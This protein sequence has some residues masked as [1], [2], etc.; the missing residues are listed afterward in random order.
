MSTFKEWFGRLE[1]FLE[2]R[3][4]TQSEI[5]TLK[6]LDRE[7]R[8]NWSP[9]SRREATEAIETFVEEPKVVTFESREIARDFYE[10]LRS[11]IVETLAQRSGEEF[12]LHYAKWVDRLRTTEDEEARYIGCGIKE[13][14]FDKGEFYFDS[15]DDLESDDYSFSGSKSERPG[16]LI[17]V[18]EGELNFTWAQEDYPGWVRDEELYDDNGVSYG[19]FIDYKKIDRINKAAKESGMN[20][21]T[22]YWYDLSLADAIV[23]TPDNVVKKRKGQRYRTDDLNKS[24]VFLKEKNQRLARPRPVYPSIA[25]AIRGLSQDDSS[26]AAAPRWASRP[27]DDSS[28]AAAPPRDDD[29]SAPAPRPAKRPRVDDV[30]VGDVVDLTSDDEIA[31]ALYVTNGDRKLAAALIMARFG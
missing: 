14:D 1:S 10:R 16:F 2:T 21:L 13:G 26:S 28:S 29:S 15:D 9:E 12:D 25:A 17:V 22:S 4:I 6:E 8:F 3:H 5:E 24:I 18:P 31:R 19:G 20:V 7:A 30:G 27:R 11:L 23:I